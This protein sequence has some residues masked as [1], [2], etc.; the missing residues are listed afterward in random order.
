MAGLYYPDHAR[1]DPT[2]PLDWRWQRAQSLVAARSHFSPDRDDK[3]TGKAVKYLRAIRRTRNAGKPLA[4]MKIKPELMDVHRAYELHAAAGS[5]TAIVQARLL[6]RQSLKEIG[7]LVCLPPRVIDAYEHLF[8]SVVDRLHARFYIS[9]LAIRWTPAMAA[10]GCGVDVV[11]RSIAY[12]AGPF[13]LEAAVPILL[14]QAA[15]WCPA[16]APIATDSMLAMQ[17]RALAA[18]MMMPLLDWKDQLKLLRLQVRVMET[19]Q[20]AGAAEDVSLGGVFDQL[21]TETV[22]ELPQECF[23]PVPKPLEDSVVEHTEAAGDAENREV[24]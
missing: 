21:M 12:R 7:A 13:A 17:I 5:Q 16:M 3:E 20:L 19:T 22:A 23:L 9:K 10:A 14:P 4:A 1:Y 15:R 18:A 8:F 6:A 2:R 11:L 24:A